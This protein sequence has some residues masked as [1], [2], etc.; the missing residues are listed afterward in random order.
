MQHAPSTMKHLLAAAIALVCTMPCAAF[1][2]DDNR[3]KNPGGEEAAKDDASQPAHWFAA[4]VKSDGLTMK[5]DDKTVKAGERS[6]FVGNTHVYP[7]A[8]F[9][10][11]AQRI[12][13]FTPGETITL[14]GW[15]KAENAEIAMMC[16]QAWDESGKNMLGFAGTAN[17][18]GTRDWHV[19]KTDPLLIPR[20]TKSIVIRAG[21]SGK[22]KVWFDGLRLAP[23]E[24]ALL[25]APPDDGKTPL[26]PNGGAEELEDKS[27]DVPA[28]WFKAHIPADG[29]DMRRVE[30]ARRTG[31]AALL[32]ANTHEYPQS[33]ANNWSQSV[34][35]DLTGRTVRLS[36]WVKTEDAQKVNICIQGFSDMQTMTSFGSSEVLSGTRDWT[37]VETSPVRITPSV[38][39]AIVR[40]VLT[41]TGKAWF[42]DVTLEFVED[43]HD[44]E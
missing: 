38:T 42:D 20:G 23:G 43:D 13:T 41:G 4:S 12:E 33:V 15:I 28:A 2:S 36:A 30:D 16:I 29:L 17:V 21:L 9:N 1:A 34:P 11:W 27:R 22:G 10:N 6:L 24:G 7:S 31:K 32:I 44:A 37:R 5:L 26:I 18:T 25:P 8:T 35:Y 14:S 3:L 40:V 39:T 19:I